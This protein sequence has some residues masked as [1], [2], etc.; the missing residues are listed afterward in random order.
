M[1]L[2]SVQLRF[3]YLIII[4]QKHC[5]FCFF[6]LEEDA[7]VLD[8]E[9]CVP[10]GAEVCTFEYHIVYSNSYSV[11]VLYFNAYRSGKLSL[12]HQSKCSMIKVKCF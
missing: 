1:C 2:F 10:R 8:M 6:E 12:Y 11:P 9:T 3:I 7:C 5:W 4:Y